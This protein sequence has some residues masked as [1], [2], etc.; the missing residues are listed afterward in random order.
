MTILLIPKLP[1]K[2]HK[3]WIIE[4]FSLTTECVQMAKTEFP[5]NTI[6]GFCQSISKDYQSNEKRSV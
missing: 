3:L 5:L 4:R 2:F 1:A 6:H